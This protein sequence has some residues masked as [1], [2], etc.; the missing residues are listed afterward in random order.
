MFDKCTLGPSAVDQGQQVVTSK[1]GGTEVSATFGATDL[2][3]TF[4]NTDPD[5]PPVPQGN[6]NINLVWYDFW[7][8]ISCTPLRSPVPRDLAQIVEDNLTRPRVPTATDTDSHGYPRPRV[9][10][11]TNSDSH[12]YRLSPRVST[13]AFGHD[14]ACKS[15]TTANHHGFEETCCLGPHFALPHGSVRSREGRCHQNVDK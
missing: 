13:S 1:F 10:P 3:T 4:G 8:A 2:A 11:A 9:P 5:Q 6:C 14:R 15:N 12:R 7:G